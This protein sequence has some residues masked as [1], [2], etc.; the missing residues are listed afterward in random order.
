MPHVKPR[1]HEHDPRGRPKRGRPI[2]CYR[3]RGNGYS[4][5]HVTSGLASS[6]SVPSPDGVHVYNG[7]ELLAAF[8]VTQF[9]GV[10]ARVRS[11][12]MVSAT[13]SNPMPPRALPIIA[14]GA[15][16]HA[17]TGHL[18]VPP[19][20]GKPSAPAL[21]PRAF[22]KLQKYLLIGALAFPGEHAH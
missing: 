1:E 18:A 7:S 16:V 10:P 20:M 8:E 5:P 2:A 13:S 11:R 3:R 21:T 6:A 14:L 9:V 19:F 4:T 12:P 22:I 15:I 17:D